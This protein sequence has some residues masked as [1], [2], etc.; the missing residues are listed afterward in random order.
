MRRHLLL[1]FFTLV[2]VLVL[3]ARA[4]DKA[5]APAPM[6]VERSSQPGT[7][8]GGQVERITATIEA[9]DVEKRLLTVK[10]PKG[11]VETVKV[12][13]EVKNLAQ[14]KA[15]DLI[16]LRFYRG[17]ALTLQPPDQASAPPSV[18]GGVEAAKLG[19]KPAAQAVVSATGTVTIEAIDMKTRVVTM[20]GSEGYKYRVK[21][22]KDIPL[23][24][25]KVG[26]KLFATY[27]EGLAI[28]VEPAKSKGKKK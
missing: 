11:Q 1:S 21:A 24:K 15:G 2:A 19:E 20:V 23:E 22:G 6:T 14:V 10:G 7:V 8:G 26:D 13:P 18:V 27:R 9:V 4:E 5:K 12:G 17:V 28:S 25:V 3:P 16:V